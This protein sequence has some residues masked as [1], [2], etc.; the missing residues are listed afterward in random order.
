MVKNLRTLREKNGWS[1]E[2][3][4]MLLGVSQ[5]A[6]AKYETQQTQPDLYILI[7]MPR[8]LI[9]RSII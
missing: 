1:Q 9:L 5:Q 7:K 6:V 8:F 2:A 3:V 4:G